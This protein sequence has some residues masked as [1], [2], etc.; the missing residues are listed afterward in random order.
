[1]IAEQNANPGRNTD[2]VIGHAGNA[3]GVFLLEYSR[4]HYNNAEWCGV[5]FK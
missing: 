2:D 4:N 5:L 3:E 1:M